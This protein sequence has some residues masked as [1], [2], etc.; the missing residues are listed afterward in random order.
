MF[1]PEIEYPPRP[2]RN[3]R[4][5]RG[6]QAG[7]QELWHDTYN[8]GLRR[9]AMQADGGLGLRDSVSQRYQTVTLP[10]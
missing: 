9:L 8:E 3:R 1:W 4:S 10:A 5:A 6:T 7:Q 2:A